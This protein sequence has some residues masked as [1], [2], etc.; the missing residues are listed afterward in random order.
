MDVNFYDGLE[1]IDVSDYI[2]GNMW[3]LMEHSAIKNVKYYPCCEEPYPDL[4]FKLRLRTNHI[5]LH[6]HFGDSW[7]HHD[8][9]YSCCLSVARW[10]TREVHFRYIIF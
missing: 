5:L 1:E 8:A 10:S 3:A 7:N 6:V 2:E 4:T 9:S